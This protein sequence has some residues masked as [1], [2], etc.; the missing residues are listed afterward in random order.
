MLIY[1]FWI[2]RWETIKT[3][4]T[5]YMFLLFVIYNE[6]YILINLLTLSWIRKNVKNIL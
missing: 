1:S 3:V 4:K 6:V 2:I 5:R